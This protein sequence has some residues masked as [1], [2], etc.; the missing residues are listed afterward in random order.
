VL[1]GFIDDD[2]L[3]VNGAVGSRPQRWTLS[4]DARGL[5]GTVRMEDPCAVSVQ[6]HLVAVGVTPGPRP[7]ADAPQV[8]VPPPAPPVMTTTLWQVVEPI[9]FRTGSA[10]LGPGADAA[11]DQVATLI[12]GRPGVRVEVA[13]H[14]DAIGAD[15]YNLALTQARAVAVVDGLVAI[16]LPRELL[17][18]TGYGAGVVGSPPSR[19]PCLDGPPHPRAHAAGPPRPGARRRLAALGSARHPGRAHGRRST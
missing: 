3:Q 4:P 14:S 11:L 5:V 2:V 13:V 19:S 7:G 8:V 16:G 6:V 10:E 15:E 9:P 17:V 1:S 12:R 18:P